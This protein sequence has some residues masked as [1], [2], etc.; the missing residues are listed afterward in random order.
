MADTSGIPWP[1]YHSDRP[2]VCGKCGIA[3]DTSAGYAQHV[4]HVCGWDG[5]KWALA[6]TEGHGR[7]DR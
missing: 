2:F 4:V 5:E 7:G 1:S 3:F 6:A